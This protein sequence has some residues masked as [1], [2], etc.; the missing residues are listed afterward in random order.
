[1]E[2]SFLFAY[3]LRF[4]PSEVSPWALRSDPVLAI[5]E[6]YDLGKLHL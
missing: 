2:K 5:Y 1:M 3:F 6:L 4:S